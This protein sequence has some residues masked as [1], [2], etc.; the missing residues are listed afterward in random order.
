[1]VE[2]LYLKMFNDCS[3]KVPDLIRD[4]WMHSDL[5]AHRFSLIRRRL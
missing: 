1:L 2:E 3:Q 4:S 5:L